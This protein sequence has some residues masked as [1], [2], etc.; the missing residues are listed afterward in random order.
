MLKM[1]LKKLKSEYFPDA[2][3]IFDEIRYE[4][5]KNKDIESSYTVFCI[6]CLA[7]WVADKQI[8]SI[9]ELITFVQTELAREQVDFITANI[10]DYWRISI[11][12]GSKYT[13]ESL[14]AAALWF[15]MPIRYS[16]GEKDMPESLIEL[17]NLILAG[18]DETV[19]DFCCGKG[20][21][22]L[23][24]QDREDNSSYFG[25]ESK[26][27]DY[28]VAAI[29]MGLI[30]K[31]TE[32]K[33]GYAFAIEEDK[34]FD[35]IFCD[36]PWGC[37]IADEWIS[38][39]E[40][41]ILVEMIPEFRDT[42]VAA[43]WIFIASVI[44]HLKDGGRAVVVL[45]NNMT[46][47]GGINK[48]IRRRLVILGVLEAVIS[49][50]KG[51]YC[52]TATAVSLLVLSWGNESIRMIDA[53]FHSSDRKRQNGLSA[54][55]VSEIVSLLAKDAGNSKKVFF[56]QLE[57]CD[58]RLK[59]SLYLGVEERIE[60]GDFLERVTRKIT[61]GVQMRASELEELVSNTPTEIQYLMLVNIQDGIISGELPYLKKLD[62]KLE[63]YCIKNNNLIISKNPPVKVAVVPVVDGHKILASG[64][65][66]VLELDEEK[67]NP[68]FLKAY[69]ESEGGTNALLKIMVG[70]ALPNIPAPRLRKLMIPLPPM[71]EQNRLAEKYQAKEAEVKELKNRLKTALEELKDIYRK[72]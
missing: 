27:A 39:E 13:E 14:V 40:K 58:F 34:K 33:K 21:F 71:E 1:P 16:L 9:W 61:R 56:E 35:K 55:E 64:N 43:D 18:T 10:N 26:A 22:I 60:N 66:Y 57:D 29:R 25:M 37:R 42:V 68:Y 28:A 53:D 7:C 41:A 72:R 19:A 65:W 46:S 44:C 12:L 52:A 11:E 45:P 8:K 17:A 38:K 5:R 30:S 31:N 36:Y 69:L 59:P 6:L 48:D 24:A 4:I 3:K 62:E 51:L 15:K 47:K 20:T 54:D 2:Q 32:I 67:I 50:P 70:E 23:A 63:K 49:L